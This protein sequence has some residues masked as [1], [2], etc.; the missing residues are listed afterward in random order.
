MERRG[1]ALTKEGEKEYRMPSPPFPRA[2][3]ARRASK[4][5]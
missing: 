1:Q 5:L 2:P 3:R 4:T